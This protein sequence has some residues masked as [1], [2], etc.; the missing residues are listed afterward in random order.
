M[1]MGWH[2]RNAD[3]HATVMEFTPLLV[4]YVIAG[5]NCSFDLIRESRECVINLPTTALTDIAVGISNTTGPEIGKF[6]HFG[7]AAQKADRVTAPL[8]VECHANFECRLADDALVD[9]TTS[10]SSRS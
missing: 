9:S 6:D 10:S 7:L 8:I 1:T 5:G 2:T 3:I 4:G